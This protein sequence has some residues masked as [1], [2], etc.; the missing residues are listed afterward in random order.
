MSRAHGG[1]RAYF[2][3][4]LSFHKRG[5]AVCQNNS[6]V[7]I[8]RVDEA[9]LETIGGEVLSPAV[10]A[11][12]VSGVLDAFAADDTSP[13]ER[14]RAELVKLEGEIARLADA[15]ATGGQLDGLLRALQA[16]QER[17]REVL[18]LMAGVEGNGHR[19][20]DRRRVEAAARRKLGEWRALLGRNVQDGRQLL[21]EVLRGPIRFWPVEPGARVFRFQGEVDYGVLLSGVAGVATK[22]VSPTGFEPVFWP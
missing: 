4:C 10:V 6:I 5:A 21:R 17:H 19:Q 12:V 7:R 9:V 14:L 15:I 11:A 1:Q 22:L 13:V 20:I 2:Y 16:R 8:E 3:G 18:R